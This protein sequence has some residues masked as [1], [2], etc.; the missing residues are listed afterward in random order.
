MKDETQKLVSADKNFIWHP[1]TQMSAWLTSEPVVIDAGEGFYLIDTEGR[2]Y[3]DGVSSLWC[4][5]HGH[6]V[7]HIDNAIRQQLN[8]ISHSTLLGLAQTRSIELAEKL[9]AIAPEGLTKVFYSD[10]GATAVEIALKM[11]YQYFRNTGRPK[12]QK[13]V[14]LE[15]SYHGDTIGS[16]SVGGIS[17]F[18]GIFRSLLFETF[19]VPAPH[20]YRFEGTEGECL[21]HSLEK[22][23]HILRAHE[24]EIAG[25]IVEPLVQ[26][27]A[28]MI[29]HPAGFLEGVRELTTKYGALLI[30]DEVATGFGRTGRMFACE[31]EGVRPD[32]MC[33]AKGIT[34]G[35][36]PLAATL[37][38]QQVF[39]AFLGE[40][41]EHK[42]FYHG[43]TYT[44]NALGCAAA[45]A[46]LELFEENRLL[47]ALP[48]KIKAVER[49]L[50]AVSV[51]EY[52][53]DVRQCGLMAGV[54]LVKDKET[55]ESFAYEAGVGA[56]VCSA[57]RARGVMMRPLGDVVVIMPPPAIDMAT[58][59][60]LLGVVRE[61]LEKDLP[62]IV[63]G[64]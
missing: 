44:G 21:S 14:A 50:R 57:M 30:A 10:S 34:G 61:T 53:G 5:V 7:S 55:K 6:R 8:R 42:T 41:S 33:V 32:L 35:Y 28:G 39:D 43:H 23:E 15:G 62:R 58:L 20:P 22:L 63:E 2:R 54:E 24:E 27:A 29:V 13:F 1:F 51:L 48:E 40:V 11:A 60:R 46:S 4:N 31:H 18:H 45:V 19:F 52:V 25:V 36:L 64:L 38:T 26:G 47:D 37:T 12:R 9:A 16:V 49:G 17:L 3:I 56:K 59:E